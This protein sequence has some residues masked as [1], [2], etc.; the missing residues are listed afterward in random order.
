M[1]TRYKTPAM[2]LHR[3]SV[4]L[5]LLLFAWI[6]AATSTSVKAQN[7]LVNGNFEQGNV[8]FTT[9]YEYSPGNIVPEGSYDVVQSPSGSHAGGAS[10]PDHTSGTGYM[11][12]ANGA[13]DASTV[14]WGQSVKVSPNTGYELSGWSASWGKLW[15]GNT[16]PAPPQFQLSINGQDV[17]P[18]FTTSA[19]NGQ[20]NKFAVPWSSAESN[21][22]AIAV[23]MNRTER[24]GND[25]ALDDLSFAP[26]ITPPIPQRTVLDF[27]APLPAGLQAIG[28]SQ[29]TSVPNSAMVTDQYIDRGVLVAGAALVELGKNH[30]ASGVNGLAGVN[31]SGHVDY[32]APVSFSFYSPAST[33]TKATTDYFAYSPDRA[34]SS[35]NVVA[36]TAYAL[37]GS[38]VGSSNYTETGNFSPDSPLEL[39]NLGDFHRVVVDTDLVRSQGIAMDLVQFGR[40]LP[41]EDTPTLRSPV[42]WTASGTVQDVLQYPAGPDGLKCFQQLGETAAVRAIASDDRYASLV[43]STGWIKSGWGDETADFTYVPAAI[44]KPDGS[45]ESPSYVTA[46]RVRFVPPQEPM[47]QDSNTIVTASVSE[48]VFKAEFL[49]G[50]GCR[51]SVAGQETSRVYLKVADVTSDRVFDSSDLVAIF[52]PGKYENNIAANWYEGDWNFDNRFDTSDLIEAFK[53]GAYEKPAASVLP[54]PEPTPASLLSVGIASL[55]I[56]RHS[57]R[58]SGK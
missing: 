45:S 8:G 17:G 48:G 39:K 35:N 36:L 56:R 28:F 30:A 7:L 19:P 33:R 37:D 16:D 57:L 31:S 52:I 9:A 29:G 43:E 22:A 20:W 58:A 49:D 6:C 46:A 47:P 13:S 14:L 38:I 1:R 24:L 2:T 5:P 41:H 32:D 40:L 34:G 11:L 18:L 27:E 53:T 26:A 42:E 23:R 12:A 44:V 4:A 25:I 54:V 15:G 3:H 51:Y 21:L 55:F 10:F 50:R